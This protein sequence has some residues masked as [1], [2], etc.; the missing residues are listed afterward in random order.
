M[1]IKLQKSKNGQY[2]MTVPIEIVEDMK[3]RKGNRL[4]VEIALDFRSFEVCKVS[5]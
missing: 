3:L 1:R 4:R 2:H 5:T